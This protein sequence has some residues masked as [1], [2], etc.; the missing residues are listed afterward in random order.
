[1]RQR[2]TRRRLLRLLLGAG[3][4][5]ALSFPVSQEEAA[6]E[7]CYWHK[8]LGPTCNGGQKLEQWCYR[9]CAGG[10]CW[11]EWCEWRVVGSC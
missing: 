4:A 8:V 7:N 2:L 11:T 10:Y 9:C 3:A 6:A 5:S 1:M